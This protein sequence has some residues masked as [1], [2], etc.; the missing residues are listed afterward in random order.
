MLSRRKFLKLCMQST[1]GIGLASLLRP[2]ILTALAQGEIP[3][4]PVIWLELGSCT[5]ESISLDNTLDPNLKRLFLEMIELR[6]HWLFMQSQGAMAVEVI[7]RTVRENEGQ[8]ILVVEGSVLT[9]DDGRYN[10]VLDRKGKLITGIS[11]LKEIA[12][13]AKY[14]VAVG[15]CA[16]FGGPGA[17]YPNPAGA[18]GVKDVLTRKVINVPGCPAHDEWMVGTLAHLIMYGEPELNNYNCPTMFFGKTIHDLCSRRSDY[19]N[20]KFADYPGEEGCFY[21]IGCKGPVTYADCPT[22]QWNNHVNW[23]VKAGIPCIGCASPH[24]PDGMMPYF[25]HLPDIYLPGGK[26]RIEKVGAALGGA[27]LLGISTH[28]LGSVITGRTGKHLL[29]GTKL[30]E[31]NPGEQVSAQEI[32]VNSIEEGLHE[33]HAEFSQ[34]VFLDKLD[35]VIS[36]QQEIAKDIIKLK[37]PRTPLMKKFKFW[38]KRNDK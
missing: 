20:G 8:F 25:Q 10:H 27:A 31:P 35:K 23:P 17:A 6:Y 36:S 29:K 5:G 14:V 18:V 9:K 24:F 15:A 16:A 28:A 13:K 22:R 26:V 33:Q 30:P 37:R 34:E 32:L 1:A 3:R 4:P 19:N 7:D 12:P 11:L 21:K 38:G 2:N